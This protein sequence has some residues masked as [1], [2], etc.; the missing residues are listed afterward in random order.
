MKDHLI[1]NRQGH[2]IERKGKIEEDDGL[3]ALKSH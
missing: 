3:E 1:A 2:K